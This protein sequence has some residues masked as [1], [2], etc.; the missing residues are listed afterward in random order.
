MHTRPN[1]PLQFT[2][3]AGEVLELPRRRQRP[4]ATAYWGLLASFLL[5]GACW[6]AIVSLGCVLWAL[7]H[8]A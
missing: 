8:G 7:G 1:T 6:A 3:L 2:P 4:T 5:S